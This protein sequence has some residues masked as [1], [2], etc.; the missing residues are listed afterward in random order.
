M[1]PLITIK[2]IGLKTTSL[3]FDGTGQQCEFD[4]KGTDATGAITVQVLPGSQGAQE[5]AK[6]VSEESKPVAVSGVGDKASRD[7]EDGGVTALKGDLFCSVT[8]ASSDQIPGVGPLE[9]AHGAT[10]N[11]GENYYDT[12]AQAMGTLCNRIYGSGN[13]NPDLSSL[14]SAAATASPSDGGGLPSVGLPTDG[15][16]S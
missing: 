9:E 4:A 1:Q 16:S 5:Y 2:V 8:Y 13:T 11:I 15:P 6:T 10:N 3:N 7:T 12:I 14:L